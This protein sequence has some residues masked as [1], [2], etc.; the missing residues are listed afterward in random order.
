M[1]AGQIVDFSISGERLARFLDQIGQHRPL[2]K[3]VVCDNGS[4]LAD[5]RHLIDAWRQH[6]REERPHSSLGY[7]PPA[8]YARQVA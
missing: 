4:D 1:S 5:A 2:P 8:Q 7:L 6:Y 3:T